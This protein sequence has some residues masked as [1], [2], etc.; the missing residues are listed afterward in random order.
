MR[1]DNKKRRITVYLTEKDYK[2]ISRHAE[3]FDQS[4]SSFC[5]E[6]ILIYLKELQKY[7]QN[8]ATLA[9]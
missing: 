3:M 7:V 9:A 1:R 2:E 8:N 5:E 6:G 4:E